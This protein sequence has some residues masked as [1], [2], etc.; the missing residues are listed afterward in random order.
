MPHL[1]SS[2]QAMSLS[3][4]SP[5]VFIKE[6]A[7][8]S[9]LLLKCDVDHK[10]FFFNGIFQNFSKNFDSFIHYYNPNTSEFKFSKHEDMLK[11]IIIMLPKLACIAINLY[12]ILYYFKFYVSTICAYKVC[13]LIYKQDFQVRLH[14][15]FIICKFRF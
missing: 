2:L 3:Y 9:K 13:V 6:W 15:V 10:S 8:Q 4:F 5:L 14:D 12:K 7:I 11:K 1:T